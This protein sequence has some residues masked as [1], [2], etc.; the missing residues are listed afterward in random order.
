MEHDD[1]PGGRLPLVE[2]FALDR[3]Q[4][5]V[6]GGAKGECQSTEGEQ[7]T[8]KQQEEELADTRSRHRKSTPKRFWV[9]RAAPQVSVAERRRVGGWSRLLPAGDQS[10]TGGD[11][12]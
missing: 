2:E 1:C 8:D 3:I 9:S 7:A 5:R 4:T 6:D 12:K 11:R 10:D